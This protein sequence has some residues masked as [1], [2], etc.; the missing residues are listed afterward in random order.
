MSGA[1]LLQ[2]ATGWMLGGTDPAIDRYAPVC[3]L[4]LIVLVMQSVTIFY[5]WKRIHARE[6]EAEAQAFEYGL[7]P[8]NAHDVLHELDVGPDQVHKMVLPHK[9]SQSAAETRLG[10]FALRGS[11]GLVGLAWALYI[12]SLL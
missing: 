9:G 6:R 12:L 10:T 11:I 5:W 4:L 7:V 2:V 8:S 1:V 3:D